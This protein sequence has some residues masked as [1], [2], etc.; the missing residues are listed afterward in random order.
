[1]FI[2]T[3]KRLL[4]HN[5]NT[6][7]ALITNDTITIKFDRS[8]VC[9]GDDVMPHAVEKDYPKTILL[10]KLLEELIS[11]VPNMYNVVWVVTLET[12]PMVILGFLVFDENG[13]GSVLQNSA[14]LPENI[15]HKS[16]PNSIYC[17]YFHSSSF[18][19]IDEATGQKV[20][21]YSEYSSVIEKVKKHY[22]LI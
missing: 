7:S 12:R 8:S 1:M 15:F 18:S 20:E 10:S 6:N 14:D 5:S 4:K 2:S 13:R 19:W 22:H 3:L 11:F 17:K 16:E 9:M 21:Q